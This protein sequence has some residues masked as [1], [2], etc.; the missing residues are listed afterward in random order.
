VCEAL[1]ATLKLLQDAG[2]HQGSRAGDVM[3]LPAPLMTVMS[4]PCERV[5][6]SAIRDANPFFHMVEAIWMLAGR[7]DAAP[8]NLYVKNFG[9]SFAERLL[10]EPF[11]EDDGKIHDAYGRRWRSAFNFDQLDI[12]VQKLIDDPRDRQ[13]VITMWDPRRAHVEGEN[14]LKGGWRTRPCNT[15]LYLRIVDHRLDITVCCRSNDMIWG[16]HGANAVHF[17]ILQEYMA[18]R[19]DTEIGTMYQLS[20]NAHAYLTELDRLERRAKMYPWFDSDYYKYE[21]VAPAPMFTEPTAIDDDV[22]AAMRWHD[23]LGER[24]PDFKN[25]WFNTTFASAVIAHRMYR[26]G[27]INMAIKIAGTVGASDW[28]MAMVEWLQRRVK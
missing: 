23:H 19:I 16:G 7:N 12:V 22:N 14:D 24:V 15:H 17:S 20:N 11:P 2:Q 3:V 4:H 1:P 5:L 13:C 6:R 25:E 26:S 18:A 10:G 28:R 21:D 8:L 9:D 27:D